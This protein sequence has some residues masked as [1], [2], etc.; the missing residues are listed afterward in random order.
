[1]TGPRPMPQP[2]WMAR[3]RVGSVL[4]AGSGA[5]RVVRS[6][7]RHADGRLC[8]V[9]FAIASCSWTR[10]CYT[11]VMSN[12]LRQRG[13]RMVRVKPRSL[14]TE[15]DRKIAQSIAQPAWERPYV[16]RCCDVE[17]IA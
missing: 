10:R 2:K 17:G 13:F 5:M 3:V 6:V 11:V 16:L 1:M 9:S 4:R 7:T 8:A 14:N 15:L 12:D